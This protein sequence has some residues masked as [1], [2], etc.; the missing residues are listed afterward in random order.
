MSDSK[1]SGDAT[2][3]LNDTKI[4]H[5]EIYEVVSHFYHAVAVDPLLKVPFSDVA[6]W[7][8]HIDLMTHFWWIRMGGQ[9]YLNYAYNPI[10]KHFAQGFNETFLKRWLGLFRESLLSKLNETQAQHWLTLASSIG[11][12]LLTRND[13]LRRMQSIS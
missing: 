10:S 11:E 9:R 7:P 8:K 4:S 3:E 5:R 6:D 13:D 1:P 12:F 2:V